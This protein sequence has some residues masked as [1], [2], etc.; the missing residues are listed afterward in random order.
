MPK[1]HEIR[2]EKEKLTR[3]GCITS[4]H[5]L[6]LCTLWKEHVITDSELSKTEI[7]GSICQYTFKQHKLRLESTPSLQWYDLDC[8]IVLVLYT[9]ASF[10]SGCSYLKVA[11]FR[12]SLRSKKRERLMWRWRLFACLQ[13][14]INTH[15]VGQTYIIIIWFVRLLAMRPLLAYCVPASDDSE[16]DCGEADGM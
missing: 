14:S 8:I 15:T 4:H 5:A 10:K 13:H 3:Q 7:G 12:R 2:W 1:F 9:K 11:Y 6:I 16:D